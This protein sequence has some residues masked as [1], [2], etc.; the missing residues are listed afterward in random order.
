M[1]NSD[2][3]AP[4]LNSTFREPRLVIHSYFKTNE[5]HYFSQIYFWNRN[6]HV[7]DS[8]SV[9]HQEF[10]TLHT[11]I[12]ICHAGLL[13]ACPAF[14]NE[15]YIIRMNQRYQPHIAARSAPRH[16][17][18]VIPFIVIIE[19]IPNLIRPGTLAV[20]LTANITAGHLLV[21][22]PGN[23][24]RGSSVGIATDYGLDGP[25]SNTGGD[26][27]FRPSKPALGP[28]QPHVKW[29]PGLSRG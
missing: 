4:F 8:F 9:H 1:T 29:V 15:I 3:M 10:S 7:S 14:M 5:M 27:I 16:T 24:G 12:G 23:S 22:L 19:T 20:R 6:L 25:G 28:T 18:C 17:N 11:A 2:I 13:T 21:T 26:E